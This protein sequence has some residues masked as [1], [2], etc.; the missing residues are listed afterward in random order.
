MENV[1]ETN[2]ITKNINRTKRE[3]TYCPKPSDIFASH[4]TGAATGA[5]VGV[6]V[7]GPA[8]AAVGG[9]VGTVGAGAYNF[10]RVV[11]CVAHS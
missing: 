11:E 2:D 5:G 1:N 8:G 10:I 4:A 7:G 9:L 3:N 6:A